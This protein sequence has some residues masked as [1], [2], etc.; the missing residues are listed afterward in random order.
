MNFIKKHSIQARVARAILVKG[1]LGH[2]IESLKRES[3]FILGGS[4][5]D[6]AWTDF[7]MMEAG[8]SLCIP[9]IT[10]SHF[11]E[12]ILHETV[13]LIL[14]KDNVTPIHWG[15]EQIKR[16]DD[17]IVTLPSAKNYR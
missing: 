13:M 1:L 14:S 10:R 3:I 17:K 6:Q 15:T 9:P 16:S 4:S 2:H 11:D 7:K 8:K 12:Q 5:L